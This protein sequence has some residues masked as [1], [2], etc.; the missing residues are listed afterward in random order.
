VSLE[1]Q[2]GDEIVM[3][4]LLPRLQAMNGPAA[5]WWKWTR[6]AWRCSCV[7]FPRAGRLLPA[8]ARR[9]AHRAEGG[10]RHAL[11]LDLLQ[12]AAA[13]MDAAGH[14]RAGCAPE[15]GNFVA[16]KNSAEYRARWPG[17]R[18]VGISWRSKQH[19]Q[20]RRCQK[21]GA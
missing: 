4:S 5:R 14:T 10:C 12:G 15:P 6:V 19:V 8:A 2:L 13:R 18:L 7:Q 20:R 11:T 1:P 21:C 16:Q 3:T 17:K 9:S